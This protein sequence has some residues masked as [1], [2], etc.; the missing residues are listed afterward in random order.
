MC[1]D[2]SC[3]RG[4]ARKMFEAAIRSSAGVN[5]KPGTGGPLHT[6]EPVT[7]ASFRTWRGWREDV[8]R[9]R[10]LTDDSNIGELMASA[11]GLQLVATGFQFSVSATNI[12]GTL[13]FCAEIAK[14]K[15]IHVRL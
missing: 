8:A 10:C 12:E 14:N 5:N 6:Q 11:F 9:D 3:V 15:R 2:L 1:K 7:V 4:R 13:P